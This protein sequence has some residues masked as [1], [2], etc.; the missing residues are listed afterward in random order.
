MEGF[1]LGLTVKKEVSKV[2]SCSVFL[3]LT[4]NWGTDILFGKSTAE[5]GG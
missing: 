1:I 5:I 3:I 2:V 4:L